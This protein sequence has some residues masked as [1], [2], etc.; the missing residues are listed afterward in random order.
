MS[1]EEEVRSKYVKT[2]KQHRCLGCLENFPAG[3]EM[4][5]QTNIGDGRIYTIYICEECEE[6]MSENHDL[7]F[8]PVEFCY[9]EGCVKIVKNIE[10]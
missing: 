9:H 5:A 8:D 7:C 6:F 10:I 4:L 3:T 2:R 1:V